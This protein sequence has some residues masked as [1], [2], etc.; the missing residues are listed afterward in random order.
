MVPQ[1]NVSQLFGHFLPP[2][3]AALHRSNQEKTAVGLL[4]AVAHL[5]VIMM[6]LFVAQSAAIHVQM[7]RRSSVSYL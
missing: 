2:R 1:P 4:V 7:L 5:V 3:T 6:E